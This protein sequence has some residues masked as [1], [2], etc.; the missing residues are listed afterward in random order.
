MKLTTTTPEFSPL[1]NIPTIPQTVYRNRQKRLQTALEQHHLEAVCLYADREHAA[2][3]LWLTGFAPRF[4]E[5]LLVWVL[6]RKPVL[7]LG[8]ENMDYA[9][10]VAQIDLE[11]VLYQDFSL[12]DQDR[13]QNTSLKTLLTSAGLANGMNCATVGWKTG[14]LELP[15]F[16]VQQLAEIT[17][18]LPHNATDLLMDAGHGLRSKLEPEMVA[19]LE[20]AAG[21]TGQAVYKAMLALEEGISE[22]E[23]SNHYLAHGLE[24][25][26][27]PMV[28]FAR[29]IPSG[30]GSPR[31]RRVERGGYAQ[32]AFGVLG[33]LTCRAGRTVGQQDPD[34][35]DYLDLL[36]NYL[37][38]VKTWYAA[39][40][41]GVSGAEVVRQ[42]Q[43]T[44]ASNWHLAL[45]P[46]HLISYDEWLSSPFTATGTT[47]HSGM[48]I[49]QDLI[50]VP[51]SSVAVINMEDGLLLADAELQAQ[52]EPSLLG[53]CLERRGRMQA[54]GYE[55]HD[56]V[57]PLSDISGMCFPFLLEPNV[58]AK[59]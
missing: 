43:A 24:H 11:C 9:K 45:N 47:L 2:N 1:G 8:N 42:T 23:V 34:A 51:H 57:L 14:A 56:D 16:I 27:H 59:V 20:Y 46:G 49:Q 30:L 41:V 54:L 10:S 55:L 17:G 26:C 40:R 6:G 33:S 38:T 25:A 32:L 35:D 37:Q 48:A 18:S 44:I 39:L 12:M 5:A 53:R 21:V 4:E 3:L 13:S 29:S 19:L 58:V 50:P 28:N 15:F 7:L 52:L 22:R 31:N 36:E